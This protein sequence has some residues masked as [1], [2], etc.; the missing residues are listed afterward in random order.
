MKAFLFV[1]SEEE[2]TI[3]DEKKMGDYRG[4]LATEQPCMTPLLP[5]DWMEVDNPFVHKIN[6]KGER[7]TLAKS[8]A[9]FNWA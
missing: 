2:I 7:V 5:R 1:S 3:I 9:Q 6:R 8:S 4:P